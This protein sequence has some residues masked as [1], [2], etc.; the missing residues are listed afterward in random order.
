M[1]ASC[2]PDERDSQ[3][4]CFPDER[5]SEDGIAAA[6]TDHGKHDGTD[7]ANRADGS[8]CL[9]VDGPDGR[10]GRAD[11]EREREGRDR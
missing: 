10:T 9:S 11:G 5:D 7:G 8:D 1:S 3:G 4:R 2:F 6:L